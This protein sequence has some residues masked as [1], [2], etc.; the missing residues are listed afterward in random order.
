MKLYCHVCYG[1]R[2]QR[3]FKLQR[4]SSSTRSPE[5]NII[6]QFVESSNGFTFYEMREMGILGDC[7]GGIILCVEILGF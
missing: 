4:K 7:M 5:T 2:I 1:I 6:I 3:Q